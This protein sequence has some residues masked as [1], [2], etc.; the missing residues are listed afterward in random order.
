[1]ALFAQ[2]NEW[3]TQYVTFDNST[4][5]TLNRTSS[6]AVV[7]SNDF[8][9]LVTRGSVAGGN[10]INYLVGYVDADSANGRLGNPTGSGVGFW[11][12]VLDHVDFADAWQIAGGPDNLVYLANNDANHNIL[13]FELTS[14]EVASTPYRMET[15]TE[16][17]WGIEVDANGYVYVCALNGS[18]A[19]TAEVKV[20]PPVTDTNAAWGTTHDSPPIATIDLPD[21]EYRGITASGDGSQVFV[22]MASERRIL[23]FVGSP[24]SGYQQ[25]TNF[26]FMLSPDDLGI[27]ADSTTFTP[28]VLGLA[29]MDNPGLMFVAVDSLFYPGETGGYRYGRVYVINPSTGANLDT[30]DQARWNFEH[31]GDYSTGSNN[32][33]WSGFA[34]SYDVD[35][36]PIESALYAQSWYGW[37]VEKWLFDGDLS[38]LLS[39][40]QVAANI[41][42]GFSLRQN[43]PNPFNPTTTIEFEIQKSGPVTLEI[44]NLMGQKVASVV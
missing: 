38:T 40:E 20:Y 18:A 13:V 39:I 26:D 9:A 22:S 15:G 1:M 7:D 11:E 5:G 44:F 4:N 33:L 34:S 6:V 23:K 32:G 30:I 12:W 28:T 42:E 43:Y 17:I 10:L 24:T 3:H 36:E 29:F 25:D 8:V 37:A 41:P 2:T 19:N 14:T 31:A 16:T 35:V 21:G 27:R